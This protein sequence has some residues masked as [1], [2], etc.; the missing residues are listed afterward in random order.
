MT[1][2][3]FSLCDTQ[4]NATGSPIIISALGRIGGL[5]RW[6]K[7]HEGEDFEFSAIRSTLFVFGLIGAVLLTAWHFARAWLVRGDRVPI[8]EAKQRQL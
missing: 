4:P 8:D 1:T 3:L 7:N 5:E 2:F 6:D